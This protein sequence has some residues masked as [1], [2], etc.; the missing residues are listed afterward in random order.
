MTLV[1]TV[2]VGAGGA[3]NITFSSIPQTATDLYVLVSFRAATTSSYSA[4]RILPNASG[5]GFTTKLL[6]TNMSNVT[7]IS[8]AIDGLSGYVNLSSDTSNTFNNVSYYMP[9]YASA[10]VKA[11][12]ADAVTENNALQAFASITAGLWNNTGAV[13]SLVID[14]FGSTIQQ[15]STAS[16]YTITKGSGGA[17]VS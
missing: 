16:L 8:G 6:R 3:S 13:T 5:S 15:Y 7:S 2:T 1:S 9:N 12:S 4:L 14:A 11:Y 10:V 17:T